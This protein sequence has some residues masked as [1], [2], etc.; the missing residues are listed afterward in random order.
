[1]GVICA[2]GAGE[3]GTLIWRPF[4]RFCADSLRSGDAADKSAEGTR[5]GEGI[6][7]MGRRGV[8]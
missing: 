1:M 6:G 4:R 8:V 3:Q 5:M 7:K 2:G